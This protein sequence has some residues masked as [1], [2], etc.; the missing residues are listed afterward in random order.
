MEIH[1]TV[2]RTDNHPSSMTLTSTPAFSPHYSAPS[3]PTSLSS[4]NNTAKLSQSMPGRTGPIDMNYDANLV[5]NTHSMPHSHVHHA[6]SH[7]HHPHHSPT[8]HVGH[9]VATSSH[10]SSG[11]ASTATST[12]YTAAVRLMN[13]GAMPRR[14]TT[15][16]MVTS[17]HHYTTAY[18]V[19]TIRNP[20]I[21]GVP[22]DMS[23]VD[24]HD[25]HH[26]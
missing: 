6:H 2:N 11:V 25:I 17:P 3:T 9:S 15:N 19:D 12:D 5:V 13:P 4:T 22:F 7:L 24:G 14:Y 23:R 16:S 18:P 20:S 26:A 10:Y 8:Y 1:T 21:M